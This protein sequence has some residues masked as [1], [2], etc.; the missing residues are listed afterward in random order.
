MI[1]NLNAIGFLNPVFEIQNAYELI[2]GPQSSRAG[3]AAGTLT[4]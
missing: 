3:V 1:S 4:L 2:F